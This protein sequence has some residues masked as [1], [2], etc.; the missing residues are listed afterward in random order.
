MKVCASPFWT[1][2]RQNTSMEEGC[3]HEVLSEVE[4]VLAFDSCCKEFALKMSK[5]H[6]QEYF[7][8]KSEFWWFKKELTRFWVGREAGV[9]IGGVGGG[10][11]IKPKYIVWNSERINKILFKIKQKDNKG[12]FKLCRYIHAWGGRGGVG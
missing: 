1:Q 11:C 2:C 5:F 3:G 10:G 12:L 4:T 7:D 6:N 9:P 8:N